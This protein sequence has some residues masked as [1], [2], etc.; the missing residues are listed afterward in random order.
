MIRLGAGGRLLGA[1]APRGLSGQVLADL[2]RWLVALLDCLRYLGSK[3]IGYYRL[4]PP[5]GEADALARQIEQQQEGLAAV[6]A[7][8]AACQVRLS[9]HAGHEV[10]LNSTDPL[11]RVR[12]AA[13]L[14]AYGTVLDALGCGAEG[15]IVIHASSAGGLAAFG[16]FVAAYELLAP[17]LRRRLGVEHGEDGWSLGDMLVLHEACGV[18]L[19]LDCLHLQIHNPQRLRLAEALGLALAT[20]PEGVRAEVHLSSART[21]AH[22]L[23]ARN[24]RGPAVVPP[25]L[26]QH[27]DF[28]SSSDG[29]ALLAASVGL[30]PF[31]AMIEAKAGDLAVLRLRAELERLGARGLA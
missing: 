30:P 7:V 6:R 29:L 20:W 22:L 8:L 16:R 28:V 1:G 19:V 10:M 31:D 15:T 23:P 21:E 14:A 3:N 9:L 12:S 11:V 26:G 24:G 18:A 17:S 5:I 2:G 4:T 13:R 27:A 25:R